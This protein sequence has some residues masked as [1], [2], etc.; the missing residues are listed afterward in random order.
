MTTKDLQDQYPDAFKNIGGIFFNLN[1]VETYLIAVLTIFFTDMSNPHSEKSFIL[2]D[3]LF[4]EAIFP[5]LENKRRLL[6]KV[7]K[8]LWRVAEEYKVPFDKDGF[9]K[10]CE[11][12]NG[13]QKIRNEI[14]H[15][16]FGFTADGKA[17][18]RVRKSNEERLND[19]R[20]GKKAGTSKEIDIDLEKGLTESQ[21][22]CDDAEKFSSDFVKQFQEV[23]LAQLKGRAAQGN[24]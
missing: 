4:D 8:H 5:T 16:A 1:R 13:I 9:M 15:H 23:L 2:N 17:R 6:I 24:K 22:L 20:T 7:I 11:S 21:K 10:F 18:Y 14:A 12:I 3:A 19:Q